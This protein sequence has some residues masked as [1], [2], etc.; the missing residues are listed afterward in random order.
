VAASVERMRIEHNGNIGIGTST[1]TAKLDVVSSVTDVARI[2]TSLTTTNYAG[3]GIGNASGTW[4][5]IAGGDSKLQIRNFSTDATVFHAD[6]ATGSIGI[7][8]T[9]P[10]SKLE[11]N[12]A[13]TNTTAFNAAAGTSIDFSKSNLAYTTAS[14]GAFTLTNLKDGGTYTL[15]VQGTTAGTAGFTATGFTFKSVNN[16]ATV[17]GKQTLYTFI[18]MGTTVYF[19]MATGF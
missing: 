11:V 6:L 18:V 15:A 13:A 17:S 16:A 3:L 19:Y 9:A 2:T 10:G 1:P 4:G 8:T 7:G 5:K 14:P 12:G